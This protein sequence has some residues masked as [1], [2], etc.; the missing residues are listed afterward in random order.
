LSFVSPF[1][2]SFAIVTA[3][4]FVFSSNSP[5]AIALAG[6]LL[7]AAGIVVVT[8]FTKSE[9]ATTLRGVPEAIASA[10]AFG[11]MFWILFA[12]VKEPLGYAYPLILLKVMASGFAVGYV[13]KSRNEPVESSQTVP[14][15]NRLIAIAAAAAACDTLAWLCY[16]FG[17]RID[18]GAVV[19]ALAS[20]FS[21]VTI[22]LA[23]IFLKERLNQLQWIGVA[24][25][26]AGILLVSLPQ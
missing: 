1:A 7:L 19:T 15:L 24:V 9:G 22:V 16:I 10:V 18:H 21:V 26:L 5:P 2:S 6:I 23:G 20:L 4:L 13:A 12:Y 3:L 11:V 25:V 14:R 17:S 8:R